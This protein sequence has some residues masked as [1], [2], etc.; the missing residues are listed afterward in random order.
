M[1]QIYPHPLIEDHFVEYDFNDVRASPADG[2]PGDLRRRLMEDYVGEK[3]IL[4]RN[5]AI[6]Y[7]RALV[8]GIRFPQTWSFK[9]FASRVVEAPTD[10]A[11]DP[12]KQDLAAEI[13]GGDRGAYRAFEHEV[14]T[15]NLGIRTALDEILRGYRI[16]KR[17]IVWRHTETRVENLHFDIDKDAGTF[18]SVRFYYNMDDVPRIWHTT[19]GLRTLMAHYYDELHLET[20]ADLPLERLLHVLSVRLFGNW[21]SR[22]R[23]QFPRH[24]ALFEPGDVWIVDGRTVPHQVIYGRRVAG[25]FYRLDQAGLPSWHEPLAKTVAGIHA[26]HAEG[27]APRRDARYDMRGYV[28]P[29]AGE[30][31]TPP[32]GREKVSLK[33]EWSSIYDESMRKTLVRL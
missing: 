8:A 18:E 7:D 22:G 27:R 9:K 17:D 15:V 24:M 28:Y 25:T 30:G 16:T 1:T 19:H 32:P 10:V 26:A 33:T 20:M 12:A 6:D 29:F 21:Q 5:I 4:L 23:E 13:F 2:G 14:R 31:P 11:D 3:C